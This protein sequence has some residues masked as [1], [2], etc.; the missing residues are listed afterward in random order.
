MV[1]SEDAEPKVLSTETVKTYKKRIGIVLKHTG[2]RDIE[3]VMMHPSKY[4]P[5]LYKSMKR[6]WK[7]KGIGEKPST[8]ANLTTTICSIMKADTSRKGD[9]AFQKAY[10]KWKTYMEEAA[11]KVKEDYSKNQMPKEKMENIVNWVD[12]EAK[13][14]DLQNDPQYFNDKRKHMQFLVLAV[15]VNIRPKR[16]DLG[17]VHI[18]TRKPT[19]K[20]MLS[21]NYIVLGKAKSMLYL[22]KYKTAKFH[23]TV[24]EKLPKQLVDVLHRSLKAYPRKYLFVDSNG[25]PYVQNNSYSQFIRRTF[26]ALFGKAMGVSLWRHVHTQQRIDFNKM[27]MEELK[28]EARLMCHSIG[29]QLLVYKFINDPAKESDRKFTRREAT[30]EKKEEK[31]T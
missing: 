14:C 1:I 11:A 28:E 31:M 21:S 3:D 13:Y 2:G 6:V 29:Q 17:E 23:K 24:D 16:A 7:A 26:D 9:K 15:F 8:I 25:D 5:I 4:Y 30:C 20:N 27:S 19:D 10:E 18:L 22:N 12:V